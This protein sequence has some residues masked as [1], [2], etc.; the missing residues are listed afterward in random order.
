M[1]LALWHVYEV[2]TVSKKVTHGQRA[3]EQNIFTILL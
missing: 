1:D 2:A 3:G